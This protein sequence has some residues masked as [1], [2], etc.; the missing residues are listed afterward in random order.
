LEAT[1]DK[2]ERGDRRDLR[3]YGASVGGQKYY[4]INLILRLFLY[5]FLH[6]LS[7]EF[8]H[9]NTNTQRTS[10]TWWWSHSPLQRCGVNESTPPKGQAALRINFPRLVLKG[11]VKL[12]KL[13]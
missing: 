13:K 9:N 3:R 7:S 4:A 11:L 1:D 12:I 2:E 5:H 6:T 8:I 10:S